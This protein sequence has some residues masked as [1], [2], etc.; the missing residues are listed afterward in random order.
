VNKDTRKG[1]VT[2]VEQELREVGTFKINYLQLKKLLLKS[3]I[4]LSFIKMGI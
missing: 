4:D 3:N 1:I 2:D